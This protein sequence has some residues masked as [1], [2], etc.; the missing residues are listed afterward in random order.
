[1]I[2]VIGAGILGASTAYHLAKKGEKILLIDRFDKGQATDAAA[3]IICPWLSQRRNKAWYAL[4]KGGA[5]YYPKLI[6][7]L[8][9]DGEAVTGY[10]RVG[11]LKLERVEKLNKF[12]DLV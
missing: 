5:K 6:H 8:E 11:T 12:Y 2:I 9:D 1:M 4:A 10:Q 3:G 7:I